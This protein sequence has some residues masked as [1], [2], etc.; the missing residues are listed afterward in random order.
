MEAKAKYRGSF[1]IGLLFTA[2][3]SPAYIATLSAVMSEE[4]HARLLPSLPEAGENLSLAR[5]GSC[6]SQMIASDGQH[7]VSL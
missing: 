5:T 4:L 2:A 7:S 6:S 1:A 3:H